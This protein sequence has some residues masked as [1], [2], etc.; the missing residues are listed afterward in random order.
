MC[1]G[2]RFCDV[3][4]V[5]LTFG[6]SVDFKVGLRRMSAVVTRTCTLSEKTTVAPRF[7]LTMNSEHPA[8]VQECEC[9]KNPCDTRT[10][11]KTPQLLYKE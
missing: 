3:L 2:I 7:N 8:F 4:T 1:K 11:L 5:C 6:P 10:P 9:V